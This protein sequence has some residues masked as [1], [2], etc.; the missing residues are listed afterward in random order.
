VGERAAGPHQ[1]TADRER[2]SGLLGSSDGGIRAERTDLVVLRALIAEHRRTGLEDL[3]AAEIELAKVRRTH[4][5]VETAAQPV[6]R[7]ERPIDERLVRVDLVDVRHAP[8][9]EASA[10]LDV[11][12]MD[13]LRAVR[14]DRNQQLSVNF[15]DVEL[16]AA[17]RLR[18]HACDALGDRRVANE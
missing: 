6:P 15:L 17:E 4:R 12:M 5:T 11:E 9:R 2:M 1:R 3:R 10:E 14:H 7:R 18:E 8:I 13:A 16:A